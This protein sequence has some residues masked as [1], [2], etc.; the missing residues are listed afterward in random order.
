MNATIFFLVICLLAFGEPR[1][2][3]RDIKRDAIKLKRA[4]GG[5]DV[6]GKGLARLIREATMNKFS[7]RI[8]QYGVLYLHPAGER[9]DALVYLNLDVKTFMTNGRLRFTEQQVKTT[10]DHLSRGTSVVMNGKPV[11]RTNFSVAGK[12]Q[13]VLETQGIGHSEQLLLPHVEEML[14]YTIAE[15]NSKVCPSHIVI[16]TLNAPCYWAGRDA[17][18]CTE[19]ISRY[20]KRLKSGKCPGIR[21]V[22]G[23]RYDPDPKAKGGQLAYNWTKGK[24]V[25]QNNGITV[26]KVNL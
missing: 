13:N 9:N 10:T 17:M 8:G 15:S 12:K 4:V 3:Q 6:I 2:A 23:Y 26:E 14:D 5:E 22:L 24:K 18:G 21:Y 1:I 16:Y 20:V 11:F 7:F 19:E 25:L